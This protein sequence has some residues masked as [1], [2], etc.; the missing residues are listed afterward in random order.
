MKNRL[1][2]I[3]LSVACACL[4]A[5]P[6]PAQGADGWEV[7]LKVKSGEA[8]N[9]LSFGQRADASE[10]ADGRYDV[11]AMLSGSLRAYFAK[12]GAEPFWRDIRALTFGQTYTWTL[13]VETETPGQTVSLNWSSEDLPKWARVKLFDVSGQVKSDMGRQ[14]S[15]VFTSGESPRQFQVVIRSKSKKRR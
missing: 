10:R 6:L 8:E 1:L 13:W 9:K 14:G 12:E 3:L 4:F 7:A 5:L 15:Y 11:P 2:G